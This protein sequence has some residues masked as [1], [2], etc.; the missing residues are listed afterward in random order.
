M[1][2]QLATNI[3]Q[4]QKN[5]TSSIHALEVQIGQFAS[6]FANRPQESL[7]SNIEVN[8]KEQANAIN[9]RSYR[10][11]IQDQ[12]QNTNTES[13]E[14]AQKI[15]TKQHK[16]SKENRDQKTMNLSSEQLICR[17]DTKTK[18]EPVWRRPSEALCSTCSFSEKLRKKNTDKQLSQF[19]NMFK[20]LHINISFADAL[21]QCWSMKSSWKIFSEQKEVGGSQDSNT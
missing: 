8:P 13:L 18:I 3:S 20:K 21:V 14:E 5:I 12:A 7:P 15:N 17:L 11:L 1:I 19:V 4:F 2:A 16:K 6:L 10:Q 9:L